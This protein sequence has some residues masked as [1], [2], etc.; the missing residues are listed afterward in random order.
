MPR[1]DLFSLSPNPTPEQLLA[2][3]KEFVDFLIGDRGKKPD[4]YELLQAAEDLAEQILGHY[5]S[6]QN[7][8]DVLAY[9]CTPP[10]KLPYQVLYVFLY[11]CV[12]EHPSLGV[13]LDEVDTLY[14]DGL[15]HKAYATVRSLLREV[16]LMMV[17]RPKLWGENGELKYQPKAFSHMHG[18]SFTR[19]VSDLFF[20]RANGVQKILDDYPRMNEASRALMDEELSKRVY[21]S[22]MSAD[23]PVRVLLRDKLDDVKD[24][25][26]R[27]ATLFSELDN[28]DDQVGFEMR[29]EHAFALV[30]E[31]PTT[32]AS[33]VLDEIN[34]CIRD[35]MTDHGEGIMRFNHPTVV[36]PRLVAVLERAQSYGFNALEEVARNVG[37]MSL[38]TLNKAMV[39]CLLDEG[40]CT[41]P[42][43]LD[44]AD[45]WKEAALR[46]TDEAYYLSLGLRPKHL[47]Q[48]LKIKDTPGIRQ[49]LLTSDVGREHILCQDLG[50]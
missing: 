19:Q 46:V 34:V 42:W 22:M 26:A 25:R 16:T 39:E 30:A 13:M 17:P 48:L 21:R 41:N 18:A 33:Q 37:Y 10:Q 38:Q 14:G 47:T 1:F 20:D 4:V 27:F 9:R 35:W 15:D 5:H 12:R 7:V 11:A 31:L 28:L 24:G 44:A 40:F 23:D 6:L 50:L 2:T 32:Q 49:A 36:V 43:E 3:G 45:A 8:A 29:L